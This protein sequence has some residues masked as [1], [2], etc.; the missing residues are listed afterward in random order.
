V[1]RLG[2]ESLRQIKAQKAD[3]VN[4]AT[5]TISTTTASAQL[6]ELRSLGQSRSALHQVNA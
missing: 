3:V 4:A 5:T 2:G 1:S 6:S